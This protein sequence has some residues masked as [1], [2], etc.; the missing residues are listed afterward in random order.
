[1]LAATAFYEDSLTV[2]LTGLGLMLLFFWYFATE[3]ERRKR[4]IG[5]ALTIGVCLL[6]LLA[7][8]PLHER[9]KGGI[10][11]LGGS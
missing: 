4:N 7:A 2:F 5:T 6:C 10:D 1:M 3:I 9:L 11:I 8:T